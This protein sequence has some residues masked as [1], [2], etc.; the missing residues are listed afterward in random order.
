MQLLPS[1]D[2][3]GQTP[4]SVEG[5]SVGYQTSLPSSSPIIYN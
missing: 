4:A 3:Q 2:R 1:F 5:I